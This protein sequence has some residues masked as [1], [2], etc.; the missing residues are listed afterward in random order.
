MSSPKRLRRLTRFGPWSL[1]Q[2]DRVVPRSDGIKEVVLSTREEALAGSAQIVHPK[3]TLMI[4]IAKRLVPL[5]V[6]RNRI[7]RIA[8]ESFRQLKL[9]SA[10]PPLNNPCDNFLLR[11]DREFSKFEHAKPHT[12]S[13][14]QR[15]KHYWQSLNELWQSLCQR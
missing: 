12:L 9:A 2:I 8:K 15:K 6:E 7:R 11:L 5:A 14:R 10:E 13:T 1:H 3:P 4:S